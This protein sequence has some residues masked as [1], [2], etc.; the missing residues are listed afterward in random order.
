[1]SNL[2]HPIQQAIECAN[3]PSPS[4]VLVRLMQL[5]DEDGTSMADLAGLVEQDPGLAARVLAIANSPALGRGRTLQSVEH[6]LA[7]LGTRLVRSIAT[8]LSIQRLFE[9]QSGIQALNLTPFWSHALLV[10]EF[11]RALAVASGKAP[12]DEAYLAGLLHD[13]G[14]LILLAALGGGYQ[15]LLASVDDES[16]LSDSERAA[17]AMTHADIAAWLVEQW[18]IDGGMADGILFHHAASEAIGSASPLARIVWLAHLLAMESDDVRVRA[19]LGAANVLDPAIDWQSLQA[20]VERQTR[21]IGEA[22]GFVLPASLIGEPLWADL[23]AE[24]TSTAEVQN[25]AQSQLLQQVSA[26]A[27]LQPLQAE[28]HTVR[29]E[30][31]IFTALRESARILFRLPR[32]VFLRYRPETEVLSGDVIADQPSVFR[33]AN[34]KRS[35]DRSQV[36][37][38]ARVETARYIFPMDDPAGALIDRQ[39]AR[40]LGASGLFCL[41]LLA[42]GQLVGVLLAGIESGDEPRLENNTAGLSV[43]ARI[44]AQSLRQLA[45]QQAAQESAREDVAMQFAHRGR[46]VIHEAGNPLGILKTYLVLLNRKLPEEV[47]VSEE[48]AVMREELDRVA[49][50]IERLSELPAASPASDG[51]DVGELL[52]ELLLVYRAPLFESRGIRLDIALPRQLPRVLVVRDSL[53]QMLLNLLKNASEALSTADNLKIS[54]GLA[55]QGAQSYVQLTLIDSGPGMPLAAMQA[56]SGNAPATLGSR[57]GHGLSIVSELARQQNILL[58]VSSDSGQGT[59]ISLMLPTVTDGAAATPTTATSTMEESP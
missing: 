37:Q 5:A 12:A 31:E 7:S 10:A 51:L 41:P 48:L 45:S 18:G 9:Q 36:V 32:V 3:I 35:L 39:F 54:A 21:Q 59:R 44:A 6:C 8:C 29:D 55:M 50:I 38:A 1:M 26:K 53:K 15:K 56:L 11:S 40:A 16:L 46:R 49:G 24:T 57:R 19:G 30:G 20:K 47:G 52:R 2:P 34:L 23:P 58:T 13:V 28:L 43:F 27:I 33:Q 17:M 42:E 22:L 25:S 14:Q 4:Q